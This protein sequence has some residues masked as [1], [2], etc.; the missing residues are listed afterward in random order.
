MMEHRRITEQGLR[1]GRPG[2]GRS[3]TGG[4]P[5]DGAEKYLARTADWLTHAE[6]HALRCLT[7]LDAVNRLAWG[8]DTDDPEVTARGRRTLDRFMRESRP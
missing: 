1:P 7:A 4:R 6:R 2:R 8:P 5:A 3:V